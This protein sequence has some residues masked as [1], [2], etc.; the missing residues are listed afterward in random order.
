MKIHR[1]NLNPMRWI[2]V[3]RQELSCL[4]IKINIFFVPKSWS[5]FRIHRFWSGKSQSAGR[6]LHQ[7]TATSEPHST[8]DCWNGC[9]GNST[10]CYIK[11]IKSISRMC[12]KNPLPV[13]D[14]L[15]NNLNIFCFRF[16]LAGFRWLGLLMGLILSMLVLCCSQGI[17]FNF[18]ILNLVLNR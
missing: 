15:L 16:W 5:F 12:F 2:D 3:N 11:T 18:D 10:V 8:Q 13:S 14:F 4:N 1:S 9:N 6:S 7:W 17:N